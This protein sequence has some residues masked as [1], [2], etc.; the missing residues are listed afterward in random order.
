MGT[1]PFTICTSYTTIPLT[2][3]QG[4][5]VIT[6]SYSLWSFKELRV[7]V[8][9]FTCSSAHNFCVPRSDLAEYNFFSNVTE[10]CL[11]VNYAPSDLHFKFTVYFHQSTQMAVGYSTEVFIDV[12]L[13]GMLDMFTDNTIFYFYAPYI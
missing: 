4:K 7:F 6:V 3:P 5:H 8:D 1:K 10:S 13:R 12:I 9:L 2:I 11:T